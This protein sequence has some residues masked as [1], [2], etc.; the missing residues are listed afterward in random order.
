[1]RVAGG[2]GRVSASRGI[3]WT[4]QEEE[5]A[6]SSQIYLK[7]GLIEIVVMIIVRWCSRDENGIQHTLYRLEQ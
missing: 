5:E 7:R 6:A 2:L 1:M 4:R 3:D